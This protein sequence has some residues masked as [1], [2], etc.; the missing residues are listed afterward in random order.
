MP[1][2]HDEA[3]RERTREQA[4]AE[5]AVGEVMT[6]VAVKAA[7]VAQKQERSHARPKP[8]KVLLLLA[9]AAV[10]LYL[11]LGDPQWLRFKGPPAPTYRYYQDGWKMAA[12]MQ[13]QRVEEARRAQ[14]KLPAHGEPVRNPVRTGPAR[15]VSD[16]RE[17]MYVWVGKTL[18]RLGLLTHGVGR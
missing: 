8:L 16:S 13:T 17:T 10:N 1:E 12:S 7:Q 5:A 18:L 11:W 14:A 2:P 6:H 9:L 4:E 3:L 15:V